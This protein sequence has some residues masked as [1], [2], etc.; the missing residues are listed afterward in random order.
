M[1]EVRDL[2]VHYGKVYALQGVNLHVD[3]GET[4]AVLGANGA[5]KSTLLN[6]IVGVI[7][8]S[9]GDVL[10]DGRSILSLQAHEIRTLGLGYVPE[11]RR[12]FSDM[13]VYENLVIGAYT[14]RDKKQQAE[15]LQSVYETFPVLK[16]R[17]RQL[18]GT[19][20]GGEQQMLA[21]GRALMSAPNL[22][23]LDEPSLGL[24]PL[25]VR[26]IFHILNGINARGVTILLVEQSA[27]LAL[28]L[29]HRAY[30]L[31]SGEVT[32]E[33][34]ATE[35]ASSSSVIEAYLGV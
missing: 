21:I 16:D 23:L 3:R 20:S 31:E 2:E 22:M 19:L 17:H 30:I 29:A 4:V 28:K 35:I 9:G 12:V 6:T 24:A 25:V 33:G 32:V 15:N 8:P 13:T 11:G 10:F 18:A 5:G 7:P 27:N 14:L 34:S 26:D 1:L